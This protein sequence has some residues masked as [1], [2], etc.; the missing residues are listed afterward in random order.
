M[1]YSVGSE[2]PPVD[3]DTYKIIGSITSYLT[4]DDV[5]V[6]LL[7]GN[8]NVIVSTTGTNSYSFEGI[9]SGTYTLVVSKT[10]HVNREYQ[11]TIGTS[12]ATCDVK[13]C[14]IGDVNGDGKIN[15][16]DVNRANLY[17]KKKLTLTDYEVCCSDVT[18]E[19]KV[20]ITDV[21]KINLH[22]KKK[23]SLWS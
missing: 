15:I 20:N 14:P 21:N 17:F 22:F 8:R 12:N 1:T 19:G 13:I 18:G 3:T 16:I 6:T 9:E 2:E 23:I 5:T 11:V 7:D 4:D 10:N